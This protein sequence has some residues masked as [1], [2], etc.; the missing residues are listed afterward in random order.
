MLSSLRST[1]NEFKPA[2]FFVGKFLIV[3]L[4]LNTLYG[5]YVTK[6]EYQPDPITKV[7]TKNAV[8]VLNLFG[9]EATIKNTPTP[10][11]PV[12]LEGVRTV[13][14]F[15]GCNSLNVMIVMLAF[16]AAY[17]GPL[18]HYLWFIPL[19][20]IIIYIFN[21]L[22]VDLLILVSRYLPDYMY[23]THKYFFTAFI[24][25]VVFI[26]WFWWVKSLSDNSVK[27]IIKDNKVEVH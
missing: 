22:R 2:L 27:Q 8:Y 17:K 23:F 10:Y 16:L 6:F 18:K 11:V 26:L 14:V 7:V 9:Y 12:Y 21:I 3:Y 1:L 4:V 13:S 24:Y 20:L 5:I 19:S 15:E 25:A